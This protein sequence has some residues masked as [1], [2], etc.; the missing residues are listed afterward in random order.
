MLDHSRQNSPSSDIVVIAIVLLLWTG[1]ASG[2]A[3]HIGQLFLDSGTPNAGAKV[4]VYSGAALATLYRD[5]E[6]LVTLSN[7]VTTSSDGVYWFY[8]DNGRYATAEQNGDVKRILD[9]EVHVLDPSDPHTIS[10]TSEEVALTLRH[11][12]SDKVETSS[13]IVLRRKHGPNIENKGPWRMHYVGT[14]R[15]PAPPRSYRLLYNTELQ[16]D[17]AGNETWAPR[18]IE[19]VCILFKTTAT[20][21]GGWSDGYLKY[22][23]APSGPAGTAPV[24]NNALNYA[25]GGL[26]NTASSL[27]KVGEG[28]D[29]NTRHFRLR[30]QG[31]TSPF[32]FS[33]TFGGPFL[34]EPQIYGEVRVVNLVSG[35]FKLATSKGERHPVVRAVGYTYYASA[36]EA[37]VQLKTG[38][39]VKPG[40][41]MVTSAQAGC[42]EVDNAQMDISRI[43]GWAVE[44]SGAKRTGF[45]FVI[46]K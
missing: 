4:Y 22:A 28:L 27:L 40:D 23:V 19:D 15:E 11:I 36:G 43:I 5:S 38:E 30:Y 35:E 25:P 37:F 10:A 14:G 17:A 46:L 20:A 13:S 3:K 12:E 29:E 34:A 33:T 45:V 26:V 21:A 8:A 16:K 32:A 44:K 24:F 41:T 1:I 6:G 39:V 31:I 42:A 2:K 7:P 18:D 9:P